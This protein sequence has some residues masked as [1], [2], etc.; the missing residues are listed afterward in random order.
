MSS[1]EVNYRL[2]RY[3]SNRNLKINSNRGVLINLTPDYDLKPDLFVFRGDDG[4]ILQIESYNHTFIQQSD[5][6]KAGVL[7]DKEESRLKADELE[8]V[9]KEKTLETYI[10][11]FTGRE[12]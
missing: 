7:T 4:S 8:H 9:D 2:E 1:K 10:S 12:M 6:L 11:P 5:Y 3:V